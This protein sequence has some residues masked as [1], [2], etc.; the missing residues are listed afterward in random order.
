MDAARGK[1]LIRQK[2]IRLAPKVRPKLLAQQGEAHD[3]SPGFC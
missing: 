1:Q 2:R 3:K